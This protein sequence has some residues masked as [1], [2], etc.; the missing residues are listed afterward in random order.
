MSTK[1]NNDGEE[2]SSEFT[3]AQVA[4]IEETHNFIERLEFAAERERQKLIAPGL[5]KRDETLNA[6]PGFWRAAFK[7][8]LVYLQVASFDEDAKALEFLSKIRG[9][10]DPEQP[11]AFGVEL[12][13]DPNPFFS[14]T[15]LKKE[16]KYVAPSDPEALKKDENGVCQ[17][18][19]D[20]DFDRDVD[21]VTTKIEWKEDKKNL[22]KL[23][24]RVFDTDEPDEIVEDGS[25]FHFF[26][27]SKVRDALS[28]RF[29]RAH[30]SS[31]IIQLKGPSEVR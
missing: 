6:I 29:M 17:A 14:N 10:R 18:D 28:L 7:N 4:S 31:S 21:V 25:F 20:F 24:P 26:E 11:K 22:I 27:D 3:D 5:A 8:S 12:H 16:F 9:W 30:P 19:I 23:F 13:F 1:R 2:K 15:V